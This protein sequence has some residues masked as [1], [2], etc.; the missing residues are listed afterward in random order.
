[1]KQARLLD[2]YKLRIE[3]VDVPLLKDNEV[4]IKVKLAGICGSDVHSY[5]SI[6]PFAFPPIVLGHEFVGEITEIGKDVRGFS[7]GERVVIE[8]NIACGVCDNC[9][10]GRYNICTNLKVIGF[11]EDKG[12]FAEYT[13]IPADRLLKLPD[14]LTWEEAVLTEPLAVAVHAVRKSN[15]KIGERVLI[16]GAGPIGLFT[17]QVAKRAG[18]KEVIITDLLNYRLKIARELGADR[19]I[20]SK[21]EDLLSLIKKDYRG[22]IDLVYDCV[23]REETVNQAI[24]AA[25]KGRRI[26]LVGVPSGELKVALHHIQNNELELI[27]ILMYVREDFNTALSLI[28][29]KEIK[30]K[31][32]ITQKF[33][34]TE[35]EKAFQLILSNKEETLK[36]LITCS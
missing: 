16:I 7:P 12:G 2:K 23:G 31:P 36:V 27:G 22:G 19:V 14:S 33:N 30:V 8:P 25:R 4:L 18:A 3:E 20:N 26:I 11:M 9:R 34:L 10:Q 17:M 1:M 24:N 15:Q 28:S 32:L 29:K 35:I 21:E 5:Q 13:A 6:H